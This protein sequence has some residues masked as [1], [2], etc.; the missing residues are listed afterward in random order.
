MYDH[1][2]EEILNST[3]ELN[4]KLAS[5]KSLTWIHCTCQK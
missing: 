3:W 4:V 5:L 1:Q 2:K